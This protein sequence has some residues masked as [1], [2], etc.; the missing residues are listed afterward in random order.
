[1]DKRTEILDTFEK[2]HA[3]M[4]TQLNEI[5]RNRKIY[6]LWTIREI[7]AHLSGWDDTVIAFLSALIKGETPPVPAARGAEVYNEETVSTREGLGYDHILSEYIQTRAKVMEL[8][9]AVPEELI[10]KT[11]VLPWGEAGSLQTLIDGF[12]AHELEHAQ[13]IEKLIRESKHL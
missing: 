13:D 9:R 12:G 4:M 10:T 1:M 2:S 3:L 5:D 7:L 11:S 8:I 6:P